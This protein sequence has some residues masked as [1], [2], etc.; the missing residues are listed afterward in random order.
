MMS[1]SPKKVAYYSSLALDHEVWMGVA[2]FITTE[3][4]AA[5]S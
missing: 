5:A 1:G 2:A 4:E 3:R